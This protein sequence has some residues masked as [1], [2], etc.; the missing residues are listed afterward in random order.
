MENKEHTLL[1]EKFRPVKLENYVGNE[2]IKKTINQ[3]LN[4]N[5]IQNLIFYGPAG[6]GKTTL[7][8]LIVKNLDCDYLYINASDE[9]GIETIRDKVSGFASTASF[10]P[11][12][13]VILDEADFLT[14]QAQ[15]SLR[16]VIETF[17]R[18]TRFIMTCNYVERIIDP[19]QSRCQ[20]LKIVPPSKSDVA[21]HIAWILG[22][23]NT[24]FELDDIKTIVNQFYPDLRKCL[25]TIQLSTQDSKLIID[26]SI[27]VSSN[28]MNQ[29]LKLLSNAKPNWKEIRQ[30]IANAN[31]KDFEELYRYLFDNSSKFAPGSEG[32]VAVYIN[33]YSYQANFRIDKEINCLALIAK[34]IELK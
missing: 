24:G 29:V 8:K 28:Y 32:M 33:E 18:N 12:K 26:K 22:E 13:V 11:I 20:V 5:D 27:L 23:E 21:K 34:L 4:Q 7:A 6:T 31:V 2:H 25:N 9:R 14:I 16:N 3:Y 30:I 10:K 1:V 15:A 17:S 19:L